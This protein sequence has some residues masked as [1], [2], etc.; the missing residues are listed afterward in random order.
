MPRVRQPSFKVIYNKRDITAEITP[1]LSSITYKDATEGKCDEV[2]LEVSNVSGI[3][4]DEWYPS[5]GDT[6]SV[7]MGYGAQMFSCG[8]FEIDEVEWKLS[9]D[10]ICIKGIAADITDATR[11]KRSDQ[12]E[13]KTLLQIAKKIASRYGYTIQGT[14]P[15]TGQIA[16]E[17]QILETDLGWLNH[18]SREYGYLFSLRGKVMT[19]TNIYDIE[20]LPPVTTITRRDL[21]PG[22]S[23]RDKSY[24]TYKKVH[25]L[26]YDPNNKKVLETEFSFP[27]ITNA[28]GFSYN[29]IVKKDT[30]EVRLRVDNIEQANQ[31]AIAALH[32][33]N[34]KQQAGKLKMVGNP[35]I[36]SGNNFELHE[37]GKLS[38]VYHIYGSV[39]TLNVKSGYISEA[40][41]K[42]VGY[43]DIV[44]TK[45]KKPKKIKPVVVNVVK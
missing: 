19:F 26:H 5:M 40:D 18:L 9:P 12:H 42:R 32:S 6:L 15:D 14:I 17:T 45:R 23:L 13:N 4:L 11:T 36:L 43:I 3:W 8:I 33:S 22:S 41:V 31:K 2:E 1:Y 28:D 7:S 44:K 35:L 30:K 37:C 20:G 29:G 25:L 34:S 24:D 39:H 16:R 10:I 38:G 21:V 27:T